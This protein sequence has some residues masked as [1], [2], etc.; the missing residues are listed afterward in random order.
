MV[1]DTIVKGKY[2]YAE[3]TTVRTHKVR[4]VND[5]HLFP[6]SVS[7]ATVRI[8]TDDIHPVVVQARK[9]GPYL[10]PNT[11]LMP[12]NASLYIMNDSDS[13]IQLKEDMVVA[14]GQEALHIEEVSESDGLLTKWNGQ[15][16]LNQSNSSL[17]LD[18]II[19]VERQ[20][21][22]LLTGNSGTISRVEKDED[23][24]ELKS[25]SGQ[26]DSNTFRGHLDCSS[27]T[28]YE[29]Y[30]PT[31]WRGTVQRPVVEGVLIIDL[32]GWLWRWKLPSPMLCLALLRRS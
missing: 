20:D 4:L 10:V 29:R 2:K 31:H 13:H 30:V 32:E 23:I 24:Q 26:L 16:V 1:N 12:G 21:D 9:N 6:N 8:Q 19:G 15:S 3:A 5:C 22:P 14:V 25:K 27:P 11:L 17:H 28:S 7:R 18:G